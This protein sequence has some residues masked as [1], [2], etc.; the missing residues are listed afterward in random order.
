ME[1]SLIENWD[2]EAPI[3]DLMKEMLSQKDLLLGWKS[4]QVLAYIGLESKSKMEA[5]PARSSSS[6]LNRKE[7]CYAV[8][9][10]RWSWIRCGWVETQAGS[11]MR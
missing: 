4:K 1:E 11:P 7:P 8:S 6:T 10:A 3:V 5:I 2:G 9:T